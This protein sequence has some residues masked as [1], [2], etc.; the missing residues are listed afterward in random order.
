[1]GSNLF[2]VCRFW[3]VPKARVEST[4]PQ[5]KQSRHHCVALDL[6]EEYEMLALEAH[7]DV[8][9][10]NVSTFGNVLSFQCKFCRNMFKDIVLS[11][12]DALL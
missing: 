4:N 10:P 9:R 5:F 11:Q 8:K 3:A 6:K 1:M 7:F 2:I 12:D